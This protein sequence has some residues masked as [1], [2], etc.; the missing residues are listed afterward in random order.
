VSRALHAQGE[1]QQIPNRSAQPSRTQTRT[2][3][4]CLAP[5]AN[6]HQSFSA[7]R[8]RPLC[9]SDRQGTNADRRR[10]SRS[11]GHPMR[12]RCFH[13][14]IPEK[15]KCIGRPG[16]PLHLPFVPRPNDSRPQIKVRN[17]RAPGVVPLSLLGTSQQFRVTTSP[18]WKCAIVA[19][20]DLNLPP[21]LGT[22]HQSPPQFFSSPLAVAWR[23][24][25]QGKGMILKDGNSCVRVAVLRAGDV[26]IGACPRSA[27]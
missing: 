3:S 18:E 17:R 21:L 15:G 12:R 27:T 4:L 19:H 26:S 9:E 1:Q 11:C 20:P 5:P 6:S 7:A 2:R 24:H 23:I 22:S 13:R 25:H 8:W 10:F 16:C 14:S